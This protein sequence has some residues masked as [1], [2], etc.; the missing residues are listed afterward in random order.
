M[1]GWRELLI[2]L[3]IVLLVF[4]TKKLAGVGKDLGSA[5]GGF[6]K[7][8]ADSNAAASGEDPKS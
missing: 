3:A 5:I 2:V 8:L 1:V 4:G 7:S 6:K